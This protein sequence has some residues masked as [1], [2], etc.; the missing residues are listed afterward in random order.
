MRAVGCAPLYVCTGGG[1]VATSNAMGGGSTLSTGPLA[2]SGN[3]LSLAGTGGAI[4]PPALSVGGNTAA[5]L[6]PQP[7]WY[8]ANQTTGAMA[9]VCTIALLCF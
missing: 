1:L 3:A 2:G 4:G 5:Y 7:H 8:N 9:S 6:Q